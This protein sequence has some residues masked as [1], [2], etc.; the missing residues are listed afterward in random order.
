[1]ESPKIHL[2][3][4]KNPRAENAP[5]QVPRPA[6]ERKSSRRRGQKGIEHQK[7]K[8]LPPRSQHPHLELPPLRFGRVA[9]LRHC[10]Q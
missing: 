10:L 4:R 1:M 9:Y 6:T 3:L 5:T 8:M 7:E 2:R